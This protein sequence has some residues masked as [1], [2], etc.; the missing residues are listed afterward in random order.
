VWIFCLLQ[1]VCNGDMS[2][3][4]ESTARRLIEVWC[5]SRTVQ[6]VRLFNCYWTGEFVHSGCYQLRHESS[7]LLFDAFRVIPLHSLIAQVWPTSVCCQ[8]THAICERDVETEG[9]SGMRYFSHLNR[10][11]DR[12]NLYG[13]LDSRAVKDDSY[14]LFSYCPSTEECVV[15][16]VSLFYTTNRGSGLRPVKH[17]L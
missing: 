7:F 10:Y 6:Y 13:L 1:K 15:W 5:S 3:Y 9:S 12:T 8:Y 4:Y 16:D 17:K 2:V 14:S 11:L